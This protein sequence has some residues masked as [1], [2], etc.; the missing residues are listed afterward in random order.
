MKFRFPIVIIDE[1]FRSENTS[2]LGIRALAEAIEREGFEVL[3]ATSYGDLSQFAQQQSRA[4]AAELAVAAARREIDAQAEQ[5]RLAAARRDALEALVAD[6]R[7]KSEASEAK[8]GDMQTRL[9]EAEAARLTD[10]E[11]A[12]ALRE[13]LESADA[14]L[15]AMTLAL[16]ESRK[17]AEETLTLLAAAEAARDQATAQA[18][19]SLTE[20]ERQAAQISLRADVGMVFQSFNLFAHKTVLQN[21]SVAPIK[22]KGVPRAQAEKEAM[23][24]LERVGP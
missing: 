2:G 19:R 5:A 10:A 11:A 3:G 15:T 20:A 17:R 18:T 24:L 6:L 12:R 21:V 9:T 16:E 7:Q 1:D 23:A 4:S 22:V 14:E 13:R 8:A